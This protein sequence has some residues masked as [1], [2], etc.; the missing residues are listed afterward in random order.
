MAVLD[1][2]LSTGIHRSNLSI[3]HPWRNPGSN[4]GRY[5][6][7]RRRVLVAHSRV[8]LRCGTL[9]FDHPPFDQSISNLDGGTNDRICNSH[10]FW[11]W[12]LHLVHPRRRDRRRS[13]GRRGAF[14]RS[15]FRH[16]VLVLS[17]AEATPANARGHDIPECWRDV[18]RSTTWTYVREHARLPGDNSSPSTAAAALSI[19]PSLATAPFQSDHQSILAV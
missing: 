11:N 3:S 2:I 18:Q 5:G 4:V 10:P 13:R 16:L 19:L 9:G 6:S 7:F 12:A 17:R 1:S 8:R 15:R 14:D